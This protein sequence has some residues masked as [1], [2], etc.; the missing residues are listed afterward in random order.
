MFVSL[1]PPADN[2]PIGANFSPLIEVAGDIH[3]RRVAAIAF[4]KGRECSG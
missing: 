1:I 3:L 2:L 4:R